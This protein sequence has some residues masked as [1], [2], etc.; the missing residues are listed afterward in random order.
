MGPSCAP[1]SSSDRR[2]AGEPVHSR[3]SNEGRRRRPT[4]GRVGVASAMW[5]IGRRLPCVKRS[6]CGLGGRWNVVET[7]EEALAGFLAR[8]DSFPAHADGLLSDGTAGRIEASRLLPSADS[9]LDL[10][11]RLRAEAIHLFRGLLRLTEDPLAAPAAPIL[12]RSLLECWMH[13]QWIADGVPPS[14]GMPATPEG[15]ARCLELGNAKTL[16]ENLAGSSKESYHEGAESEAREWLDESKALH[17]ETGCQCSGRTYIDVRPALKY[18]STSPGSSWPLD[19]WFVASAAGHGMMP[20]RLAH[21]YGSET[22]W[23]GPSTPSERQ[24]WLARGITCLINIY[25]F[26]IRVLRP[27]R[28]LDYD[29][30]A[31]AIQTDVRE[32]NAVVEGAPADSKPRDQR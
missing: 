2:R 11:L 17:S 8:L 20:Q 9:P 29:R 32:V 25:F 24:N 5:R 22:A 3:L 27:D 4:A 10:M 31:K 19:T 1:R 6:N 7:P 16:V 12:V 30:L 13:L 28:L 15:R 26:V 18:L 21:V 14:P 23:G